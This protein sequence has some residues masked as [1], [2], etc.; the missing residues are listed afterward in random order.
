MIKHDEHNKKVIGERLNTLLAV[1]GLKQ[2]DI[3][4]LL[5]VTEN[6]VSYYVTGARCPNTDQIIAIAKK[7]NVSADYLLGL[8]EVMSTD[9]NKKIAC[10]VTGLSEENV[11]FLS[12]LYEYQEVCEKACQLKILSWGEWERKHSYTWYINMLLSLLSVHRMYEVLDLLYSADHLRENFPFDADYSEQEKDKAFFAELDTKFPGVRKYLFDK[13]APVLT[14]IQ[15]RQFYRRDIEKH[16]STLGFL[17]FTDTLEPESKPK[18]GLDDL[19][20][21][22]IGLRICILKKQM[23]KVKG[24]EQNANDHTEE[25]DI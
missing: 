1:K 24:G 17:L 8:S 18:R 16:F 12:K 15:A 2:K 5:G 23:E 21:G 4:D 6:T 10:E 22:N 3:A 7:W 25:R 14:G 20:L 13:G 11:E 19:G 9:Q